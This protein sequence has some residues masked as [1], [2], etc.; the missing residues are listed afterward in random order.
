MLWVLRMGAI[1]LLSA[2]L[3]SVG[4]CLQSN[5]THSSIL[6]RPYA[7]QLVATLASVVRRLALS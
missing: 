7:Y 4:L 2:Q 3:R 6:N 5:Y 1:K